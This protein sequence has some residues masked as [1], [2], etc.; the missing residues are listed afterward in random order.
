MDVAVDAGQILGVRGRAGDRGNRGRLGPK[1]LF[2]WQ[3][4]AAP[5]RLTR[6]LVREAGRLTETDWPTAME[7]IVDRS[8]H[9]L[10][11]CGPGL[12]RLL[13]HRPVVPGGVLHPRGH[14]AGR[15]RHQPS[16]R[17]HPSVHSHRRRGPQADF[18]SD[19]QPGSYAD[20]D[21][22]DTL[23]LFGH[24]MAETQPVLWM[25]VLDRLAGRQP[26]K[27]DFVHV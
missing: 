2:A 9:L 11:V 20:L 22:A 14:R 16:G 19:G 27:L 13:H 26:P 4:N 3:A 10:T 8:R 15:A 17:Q 23:A 5:D 7:R 1:E 18:G 21:Q 12:Y 24:N 6:P 25:R